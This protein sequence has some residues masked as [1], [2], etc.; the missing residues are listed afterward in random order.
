LFDLRDNFGNHL[1]L[2]E[3]LLDL[4]HATCALFDHLMSN[5]EFIE[6][7]SEIAKAIAKMDEDKMKQNENWKKLNNM[8]DRLLVY[9]VPK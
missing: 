6:A 3:K 2:K 5:H 1:D 8:L 7:M 9:I 4:L